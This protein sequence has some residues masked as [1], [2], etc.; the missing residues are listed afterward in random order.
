MM[1]KIISSLWNFLFPISC[2]ECA[3]HGS[4]LCTRCL[5]KIS[6]ST[7]QINKNIYSV[8]D[9]KH[10]I[11]KKALWELK[12][13][14]N[15]SLSQPLATALYDKMLEEIQD[16]ETF[17]NF[18]N[19][20]LVP[21]P[22]SKRREKLRGYNQSELLCKELAIID[23]VS[24]E[25]CIDVLRKPT[26]TKQQTKTLT[27]AERKNNLQGCFTVK[28]IEKI[29]GRNI[30]LIDD[31]VTTGATIFETK[32]VLKKAGAKKIIAFTVAH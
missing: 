20:L 30:I 23:S 4:P 9:Y 26:D 32:K 13:K 10:P 14:N 27:K 6:L 29:K 18:T 12:F 8:F 3:Q 22:L 16:L 17:N 24:F 19:P 1:R 28:N 31:I 7:N 15:K 21:I 11:I 2:V 25:L 5:S